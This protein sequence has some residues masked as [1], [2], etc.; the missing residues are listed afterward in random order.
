[1][2]TV[3]EGKRRVETKCKKWSG[4]NIGDDGAVELSHIL[5]GGVSLSSINISGML[6]SM[7]VLEFASA[8]LFTFFTRRE[9]HPQA[10]CKRTVS[11]TGV[12]HNTHCSR[13]KWYDC[14]LFFISLH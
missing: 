8:F 4:N 11:C 3:K 7:I 1:M 2:I 10:W 9:Q 5:S 12:Q 6:L 14:A 13:H